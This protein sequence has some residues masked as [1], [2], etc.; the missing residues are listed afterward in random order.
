MLAT[1][2]GQIPQPEEKATLCQP[3][4][5][6]LFPDLPWDEKLRS[7]LVPSCVVVFTAPDEWFNPVPSSS[8]L[9]VR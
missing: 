7:Y 4:K 2:R 6:S 5:T 8:M 9:P 1:L 3:P